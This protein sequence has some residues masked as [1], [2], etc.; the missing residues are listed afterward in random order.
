ML[1]V[2]EMMRYGSYGTIGVRLVHDERA[3]VREEVLIVTHRAANVGA[4]P[5][6]G[7]ALLC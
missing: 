1:S 2:R 7:R 5:F 6:P 4:R 3:V